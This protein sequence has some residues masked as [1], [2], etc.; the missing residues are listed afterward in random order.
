MQKVDR[1]KYVDDDRSMVS[2]EA[3]PHLLIQGCALLDPQGQS[4]LLF[5]Q[6]ILIVGE[7]IKAVGPGGTLPFNSLRI[8][9]I[10]Q[11]KGL[12]AIP[13]L[14]N[15]H[16]HSLENLLKA[17]SPSL[18]LELWLVPLFG[19]TV[20]WSP[21]LVYLSALLGA[22]EMLKSGTTAVLDHL[23]TVDGVAPAYLNATMQAYHDAGIRAAVAPSIED[24]DL[25]LE[26]GTKR[27]LVFP[28]HPFIDRFACWPTIERQIA[29]LEQFI[30]H[31]HNA[32]DGRLRCFV[33]PS[34]IHWCSPRLM[35]ACL[36]L[37]EQYDTG[38]HLHAVETEL[39]AAV[40]RETLGQGGIAYL[41]QLG[42]LKAG[43]SLAHAIWLEPG[44][45]ALLAATGTTAVHNPV[46]NLRLGSGRFPFAEA[47]KQG[48]TIALGS[49]GSASNDTQN[50]FGVL[51]LTGLI[52]NQP[53]F[54]YRKWPR[55]TEILDA[56]TKGGAAAL[57]LA[58]E[59]GEIAPGYLADLALLNLENA[60]FLPLRDPYLH[61]VYCENGYSVDTVIVHGKI[62][63]ER[64]AI[65]TVDEMA[66]RREIRGYCHPAGPGVP[67]AEDA[68]NTHEVLATI[69]T[70]RELI[71]SKERC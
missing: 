2:A 70:L 15:A 3:K 45:L 35:Q 53:N 47:R 34:G 22:I 51:K 10:I 64:G 40:I 36:E 7:Q 16:T 56:A 61:L 25:V 49:D 48:V 50:M 63:V 14:I 69:D 37:A 26:A 71:L 38:I 39:Q 46:S 62:V 60:A 13:G 8:D 33:G 23:W 9:R 66:L 6:D 5:D 55:P 52:H 43:T 12:V 11:G 30:T 41:D 18:P 29:A 54:D 20:E 32:A 24:Q 19:D 31:W 44:D 67:L 65:A 68:T 57:G 17:T 58:S 59:L 27:G 42:V 4:G 21:R 28:H 1:V